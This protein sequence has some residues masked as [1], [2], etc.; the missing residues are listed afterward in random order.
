M[1]LERSRWKDRATFATLVETSLDKLRKGGQL[2]I[3][4][5]RIRVRD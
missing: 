3:P 4:H 1:L 2:E 5:E